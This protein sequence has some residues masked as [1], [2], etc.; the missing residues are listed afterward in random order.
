MYLKYQM[1]RGEKKKS[2]IWKVSGQKFFKTNE[3]QQLTESRN[4]NIKQDSKQRKSHLNNYGK[5]LRIYLFIYLLT[6]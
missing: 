4:M 5:L 1:E 3:R 6:F 2:N